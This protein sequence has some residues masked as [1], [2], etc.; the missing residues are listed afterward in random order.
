MDY[1]QFEGTYVMSTR[2]DGYYDHE[3]RIAV[4]SGGRVT[5]S[6]RHLSTGGGQSS[7]D[8]FL[9]GDTVQFTRSAS[10]LRQSFVGRWAPTFAGGKFE[11]TGV[12]Y[13]EKQ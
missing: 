4:D 2:H 12:W 10:G 11:N 8:G 6:W 13:M 3:L 9:N 1:Q 5:G 7:I